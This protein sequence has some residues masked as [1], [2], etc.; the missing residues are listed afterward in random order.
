MIHFKIGVN[1]N[2][3]DLPL[4]R[5]VFV[6]F[7]L[8]TADSNVKRVMMDVV[9]HSVVVIIILIAIKKLS[10]H[11]LYFVRLFLSHFLVS[12]PNK[13]IEFPPN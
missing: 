3:S 7:F 6:S 5:A 12:F 11:T 13:N 1:K 4:L 8:T 10:V 2:V 9:N